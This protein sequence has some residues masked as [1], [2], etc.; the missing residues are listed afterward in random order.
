M[1]TLLPLGSCEKGYY[2][3][4][5][6]KGET[7]CCPEGMDLEE[8]A[9]AYEMPGG[10]TSQTPPAPSTTST[11][12]STSSTSTTST[13][14]STSTISSTSTSESSTT[15][16]ASPTTFTPSYV[17]SVYP[18]PMNTTTISTVAPP[19]P[20]QTKIEEGAGSIATPAA[21]LILLAAGVAILL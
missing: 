15:S 14:T 6:K 19:Q 10:L 9:A 13:S 11:S 7:Y 2:C 12:T 8:C 16:V 4:A 20:T 17:P 1:L 5:D 3:T 21:A 18:V